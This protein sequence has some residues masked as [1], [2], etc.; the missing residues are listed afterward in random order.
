[1]VQTDIEKWLAMLDEESRLYVLRSLP[2]H[3]IAAHKL[4]EL[5]E[6]LCDLGFIRANCAAGLHSG[7]VSDFSKALET[8]GPPLAEH[9]FESFSAGAIP[10]WLGESSRGA[11]NGVLEP[12]TEAGSG[13]LLKTL[14][15]LPEAQRNKPV[16]APLVPYGRPG[17]VPRD[18]FP[19]KNAAI[20]VTTVQDS[21]SAAEKSA[22]Q[23]ECPRDQVERLRVFS[24][25]VQACAAKIAKNP[26]D[27]VQAARNW[28]YTGELAEAA[29]RL[30]DAGER[31]WIT[32]DPRIKQPR[33]SYP[34]ARIILTGSRELK[35]VAVSRE[36]HW[37]LISDEEQ[38][39][40]W[41]V[42]E[43]A[44]FRA[45]HGHISPISSVVI[46]DDGSVAAS[47]DTLGFIFV[48]KPMVES[49]GQELTRAANLDRCLAISAD[50]SCLVSGDERG[51]INIW[52]T[53]VLRLR[54]SLEGHT[55]EISDVSIAPDG[56]LLMSASDDGTAR[57]WDV[58]LRSCLRTLFPGNKAGK[59]TAVFRPRESPV[60][61]T[62]HQDRSIRMWDLRTGLSL[63]RF[64]TVHKG[65]VH[66]LAASEDGTILASAD[67]LRRICIWNAV[68]GSLIRKFDGHERFVAGVSIVQD[69]RF[70]VSA[71]RD[72]TLRVW[73]LTCPNDELAVYGHGDQ[74]QS[75]S[76]TKY[77]NRAISCGNDKTVRIWNR[78]NG[79]C[80]NLLRGH[81]K[82]VFAAAFLRS[83]AMGAVSASRDGT[84]HLWNLKQNVAQ[85]ILPVPGFGPM[86]VVFET[87]RSLAMTMRDD[88][89][90]TFWDLKLPSQLGTVPAHASR[91]VGMAWLS[92]GN[93][94]LTVE[95]SGVIHIWNIPGYEVA[96]EWNAFLE[97]ITKWKLSSDE[98]TIAIAN[99]QN[100]IGLYE[101]HSGRCVKDLGTLPS[102]ILGL[103]F[104]DDNGIVA[105]FGPSRKLHIWFLSTGDYLTPELPYENGGIMGVRLQSLGKLAV[106]VQGSS[107]VLIDLP[108]GRVQSEYSCESTITAVSEIISDGDIVCGTR[109]G[110]LHFLRIRDWMTETPEAA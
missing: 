15:V 71:G 7:L 42:R 96:S 34:C 56:R 59:V 70:A 44:H 101:L 102:E 22:L 104:S 98:K 28:A 63:R 65:I 3:L 32:R 18:V 105:A 89:C 74:V 14:R 58:A 64:G 55:D 8:F 31:P 103:Q 30:I 92:D 6:I 78:S 26:A 75:V 77:S 99:R 76:L 9:L 24:I 10:A 80:I 50:G 61:F 19:E 11:I 109:L 35:N 53:Q 33:L 60:G 48:W 68:D 29:Q 37:A 2:S 16:H 67:Q 94:A 93:S 27:T 84:L 41:S 46:A 88:S 43:G 83:L 52:D 62:A 1:M 38:L 54:G 79:V 57:V 73:D 72:G 110:Q 69:G 108:N 106:C 23:P 20:E 51:K 66:K 25:F 97:N 82:S 5:A 95:E 86:Q 90:V 36:G 4:D 87:S 81:V 107:V 45:L 13:S 47:L 12:F 49:V 91:V 85:R 100:R 40:L 21:R 17:T 39:N